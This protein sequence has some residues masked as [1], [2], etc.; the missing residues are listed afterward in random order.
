MAPGAFIKKEII[1]TSHSLKNWSILKKKMLTIKYNDM[2]Y[3]TARL[4]VRFY[5]IDMPNASNRFI[6]NS[7]T[8]LMF[9]V[10]IFLP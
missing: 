10:S 9:R 8:G 6:S 1:P 2:I 5:R 7:L 4:Y 3:F